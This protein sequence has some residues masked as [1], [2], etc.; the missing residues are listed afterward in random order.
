MFSESVQG[1]YREIAR[2]NKATFG[3]TMTELASIWSNLSNDEKKRAAIFINGYI[4]Y[5][6]R[7]AAFNFGAV[8][9][10]S[11][12]AQNVV[13]SSGKYAGVVFSTSGT[14]TYT[15]YSN[16]AGSEAVLTIRN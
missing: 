11:A 6:S 8:V 12:G 3:E 15:D 1:G 16:T 7:E 9:S 4:L 10:V 2:V 5:P 14:V 13:A